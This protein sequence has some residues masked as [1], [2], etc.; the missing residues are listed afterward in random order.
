MVP[1]IPELV[2]LHAVGDSHNL[3]LGNP[4]TPAHGVGD[5]IGY[6]DNSIG[7]REQPLDRR[8]P[9]P[10]QEVV[11]SLRGREYDIVDRSAYSRHS[12]SAGSKDCQKGVFGEVSVNDVNGQAFASLCQSFKQLSEIGDKK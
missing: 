4:S 11:F 5:F 1:V 6:S 9:K 7:L 8:A 3:L 10:A 2:G 12:S